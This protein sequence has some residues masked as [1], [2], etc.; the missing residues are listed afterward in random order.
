[1][2]REDRGPWYLLT[3]LVI[4][5]IAGLVYAWRIAPVKYVDTSPATLR[6]DFK[7]QYRTLI[8]MAFAADGDLERAQARLALLKDPNNAQSV[9]I[10]AQQALAGGRPAAEAHAL[11]ILA[12][13][14][15]Q[16]TSP[17][18]E[19]QVSSVPVT[20]TPTETEI[21]LSAT[22]TSSPTTS[23]PT[24]SPSPLISSTQPSTQTVLLVPTISPSPTSGAPFVLSGE[25]KQVCDA[26]L[27]RALIMVEARDAAGQP[28][29][30]VEVLVTWNGGAGHFFTGLYPDRDPGYGDYEMSPDISYT[31]HVADA[32]QPV[33]DLK[34][35]QCTGSGGAQYLGSWS[36][37][38]VQP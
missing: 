4:G 24:P 15:S 12:V 35:G 19:P 13:A 10:Q 32:G 22:V 21:P 34:A 16:Q 38:F 29:P 2:R 20:P 31:I 14:L 18:P 8:A 6:Q 27:K 5:M 7:D 3:G 1:M 25:P 33:P 26:T 36:I 17:P 9:A 37:V 28:V 23:V 11:G 30:G